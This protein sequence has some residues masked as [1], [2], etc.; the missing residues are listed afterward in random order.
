M[1][2]IAK[3]R[4]DYDPDCVLTLIKTD[5]G[6]IILHINKQMQPDGTGEFRI[7]TSGG[8]LLFKDNGAK[9]ISLFSELIDE[10]NSIGE[11]NG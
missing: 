11:S 10:I 4:S 6:D 2:E 7:T 1:M 3:L 8:Q 5:D 9:I